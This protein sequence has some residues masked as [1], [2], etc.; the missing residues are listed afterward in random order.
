MSSP[1]SVES[2]NWLLELRKIFAESL[3]YDWSSHLATLNARLRLTG[4]GALELSMDGLPPVWFNGDV[5]AII[6]RQWTLV[7][8]LNHQRGHYARI[9]Q[10]ASAWDFWRSHNTEYWYPTFFRPLV[11]I[12]A[13]ALGD[14][15]QPDDERHYATRSMVFVEICPYAS[16]RFGLP[17][18]AVRE[19]ADEDVGF[20]MAAKFNG[21]LL[22][23]AQPGLVLVNGSAAIKDFEALYPGQVRWSEQRYYSAGSQVHQTRP[24]RLWHLEGYFATAAS[25]TP[26]AGFPFLKKAATHNSNIEIEQLGELLR[27]FLGTPSP[28][29]DESRPLAT[30]AQHR[31][32]RRHYDVTVNGRSYLQLGLGRAMLAVVKGLIEFGIP[33]AEVRL[34]LGN[35]ASL[36]RPSDEAY[37]PRRYFNA[38]A[39]F[40]QDGDRS[41]VFTNQWG[42]GTIEAIENMRYIFPDAN[43]SCVPSGEA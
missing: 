21:L 42:T 6:P 17:A 40:L 38:P 35:K 5:E 19:L 1:P 15:V 37:V 14:D 32:S 23:H 41:Y 25:R 30:E 10:P 36:F 2:P 29:R 27:V 43:I 33:L 28:L 18:D 8:S 22:T 26:I 7:I 24:K 34:A 39:E 4:A 9:P 11:R 31:F 3:H 13:T 16:R 20:R 12:A